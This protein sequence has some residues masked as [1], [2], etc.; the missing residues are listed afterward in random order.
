MAGKKVT[1]LPELASAELTDIVYVV[2]VSDTSESAA[3]TSK[4][5]TVEGISNLSERITKTTVDGTT[6][7]EIA[8]GNNSIKV[9]SSVA[10]FNGQG[11]LNAVQ[12]KLPY[13]AR[14]FRSAGLACQRACG[15]ADR[16][17]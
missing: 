16:R 13:A 9:A 3:G 1:E 2:D 6:K 10:G 5:T 17:S 14:T 11:V 4:Q 15:L 12:N 7:L 8:S